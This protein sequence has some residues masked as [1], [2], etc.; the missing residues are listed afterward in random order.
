MKITLS[1]FVAALLFLSG[2]V[3]SIPPSLNEV[4][5]TRLTSIDAAGLFATDP[6]G[7]KVA[8]VQNGLI[9]FDLQS[10]HTQ[11]ISPDKPLALAWSPDGT[12][13]CAAFPGA[14]YETRLLLFSPD[15]SVRR[16]LLLPV[17]LTKLVWSARG[18]LLVVG[19][20]L[21]LFSFGGNLRQSLYRVTEKEMLETVLSDATPR[22]SLA[23]KLKTEMRQLHPV[24][25][26]PD[27][28]E[29]VFL[30][31]HDPPEFP[32]YA[33]LVYR[34][35]QVDRHSL[36]GRLP[37]QPVSLAW[38]PV[39]DSVMITT[40]GVARPLE[41]WPD[42]GDVDRTAWSN[43]YHF[44]D[45]RLYKGSEL[46]AE[47]GRGARYEALADGRFLLATHKQLYLGTGLQPTDQPA[48][49]EKHW[50]LRRW[51]YQ[52]LISAG[53]YRSLIEDDL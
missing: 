5:L 26:S 53:E 25:F 15:G 52:G 23:T 2:C 46:L 19:L 49:S 45:G 18:D 6:A 1:A 10:A 8:L 20:K 36:L 17:A 42:A 28:D 31:V 43:P 22:P 4:P 34:N 9:L 51:R 24:A 30:S 16:D 27:G 11:K 3:A 12:T 7:S 29:L 44:A 48:F 35:W 40:G 21:E 33:D 39:A 41:L 38:S 13:L 32:P 50:N 47:W 37:L 14:D